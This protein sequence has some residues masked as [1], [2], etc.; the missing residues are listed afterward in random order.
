[1]IRGDVAP[2]AAL[3]M[4]IT[5]RSARDQFERLQLLV[6]RAFVVLVGATAL[7]LLTT[8]IALL[9]GAVGAATLLVPFGAALLAGGFHLVDRRLAERPPGTVEVPAELAEPLTELHAAC[10]DIAQYG[11]YVFPPEEH[12]QEAALAYERLHGCLAAANEEL[13]AERAGDEARSA[14]RR[15]VIQALA[16][17][18]SSVQEVVMAAV[19]GEYEEDG[20]DE[21]TPSVGRHSGVPTDS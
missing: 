10:E 13:E 2:D 1:L 7:T 17:Q 20:A 16:A 18:I 4:G 19:R 21:D 8:L 6:G 11:D 5:D 9:R 15:A 14:S 12:E 3:V